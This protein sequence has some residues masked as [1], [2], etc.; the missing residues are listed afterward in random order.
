MPHPTPVVLAATL[1]NHA[2]HAQA[3][4]ARQADGAVVRRAHATSAAPLGPSEA[5]STLVGLQQQ[6]LAEIATDAY[7]LVG[8]GLAL[9]ATFDPA[10]AIVQSL[11]PMRP[12]EGFALRAE[13]AAA[14][15]TKQVAIESLTNAAL[16]GEMTEGAGQGAPTALYIDSSR[17]VMAALWWQ[18]QVMHRPHLGALGH[19]PVAGA[20]ARCACGGYGHLETVAA[21]QALVR[22]MIGRLVEAPA[23][24]AAVMRLTNGRA[25]AL[26]APQLWQLA[27]EKDPIAS[28][29]MAAANAALAHTILTLLLALD[30]E[31]VILGGALAQSGPTWLAV[32]QREVAQL[33]PPARAEDLAAR[34][35]LGQLGPQAVPRGVITMARFGLY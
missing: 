24:E 35:A 1:T 7:Q 8:A 26:T 14:L 32:V 23:T 11:H 18:G 34:L 3:V 31:R 4:L 16:M 5:L 21:A 6:M 17:S 12:W 15:G 19:I 22:W 2:T 29:L 13:L 20:T 25:E 27:C 30:V 9:D 10:H 28:A 33:A